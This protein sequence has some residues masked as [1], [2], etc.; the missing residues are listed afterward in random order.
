MSSVLLGEKNEWIVDYLFCCTM[1]AAYNIGG[2]TISADTIQSSILG[3]R[4]SRPGQ[5]DSK[6][7]IFI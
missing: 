2:H 1:Q 5:V 6:S 4:M 7:Y 3:C